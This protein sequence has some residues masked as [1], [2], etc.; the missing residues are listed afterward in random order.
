MAKNVDDLFLNVDVQVH[1][2]WQCTVHWTRIS[3]FFPF[4]TMG[5]K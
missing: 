1:N 3:E 4:S 5:E 2:T